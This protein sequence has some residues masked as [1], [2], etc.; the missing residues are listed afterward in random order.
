[1]RVANWFSDSYYTG[2]IID[3][4]RDNNGTQRWRV[5]YND[6]N[7]DDIN[8]NRLRDGLFVISLYPDGQIFQNSEPSEKLQD[9]SFA[10]SFNDDDDSG[11]NSIDTSTSNNSLSHS[12]PKPKDWRLKHVDEKEALENEGNKSSSSKDEIDKIDNNATLAPT[13]RSRK[14]CLTNKKVS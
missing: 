3:T 12:S 1:M 5:L 2:E 14:P 7:I 9:H 11:N 13:S 8:F 10:Q 6:G 4:Y